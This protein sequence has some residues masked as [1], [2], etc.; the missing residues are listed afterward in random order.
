MV[1]ATCAVVTAADTVRGEKCGFATSITTLV[2]SWAN[3][4]W[5]PK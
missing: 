2:S 4:P 1:G 3:P 5:S